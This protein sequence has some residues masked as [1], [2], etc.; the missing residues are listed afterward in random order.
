MARVDICIPVYN[1]AKNIGRL[2]RRL[3]REPML[4][5]IVVVSSG[6]TNGTVGIAESIPGVQVLVQERR[7]GKASAINLF[8]ERSQA[9]IVILESGDTLP[10]HG[11]IGHLL[12]HFEDPTVGMVGAHPIPVD[13]IRTVMGKVVHLLW[14]S[15]HR[16]SKRYPKA[17][18]VVAFRR[19]L[20]R[21]DPGTPVD[22]ACIEREIIAQGLRVVYEPRAVIFNKGAGGIKD[23]V[24]QR[25]RIYHGHLLLWQEGYTVATM[26]ARHAVRA[27]VGSADHN[28][29]GL[30]ALAVFMATE[31]YSRIMA[32]VDILRGREKPTAWAMA[33]STKELR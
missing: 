26:K 5:N 22:E 12:S 8:L 16:L 17:G 25:R 4:D 24:R 29:K 30:V 14:A 2:L 21:I 28:V 32:H 11:C 9:D 33:P 10:G 27:V 3:T 31:A 15:H 23:L 1:E 18:E 13:G 7:E 20:S 6:C 19:V